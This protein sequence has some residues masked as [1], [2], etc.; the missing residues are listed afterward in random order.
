MLKF[1]EKYYFP[2]GKTEDAFK[3]GLCRIIDPDFTRQNMEEGIDFWWVSA[4]KIS[5]AFYIDNQRKRA[6]P[7]D[8]EVTEVVEVGTTPPKKAPKAYTSP[9]HQFWR[10]ERGTAKTKKNTCAFS[11]RLLA[12]KM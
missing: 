1:E 7:V 6:A 5:S 11:T 8:E 4:Q 9:V 12:S 10:V 2:S 3:L